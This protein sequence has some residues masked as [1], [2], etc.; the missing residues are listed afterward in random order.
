MKINI[1]QTYLNSK[2]RLAEV[3]KR[4]SAVEEKLRTPERT[5][6]DIAEHMLLL[7]EYSRLNRLN[8]DYGA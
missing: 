2:A 1:E 6:E 7:K 5:V 3:E 4:L 8:E